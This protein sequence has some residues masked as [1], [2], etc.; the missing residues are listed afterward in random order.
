MT[1]SATA[2][3]AQWCPD[4][5]SAVRLWSKCMLTQERC[6]G[7]VVNVGG[8]SSPI[9]ATMHSTATMPAIAMPTIPA[10]DSTGTPLSRLLLLLL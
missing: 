5:G 2:K 3:M 8:W 6:A 4:M 10:G 9:R 7:A 1:G